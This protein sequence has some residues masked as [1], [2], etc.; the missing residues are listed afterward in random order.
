MSG[1]IEVPM[2]RRRAGWGARVVLD[3]APEPA[4]GPRV[5]AVASTLALA[6]ALQAMIDRGDVRDQAELAERLG[7]TR[8]RITQILDLTLLAPDIQTE[9]LFAIENSGRDRVTERDLRRIVR[10]VAWSEQ[11]RAWCNSGWRQ[12]RVRTPT[13]RAQLGDST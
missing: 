13:G 2:V 9:I 11:R 5:P 10:S 7:F 6:H 8:A 3:G 4:A 1:V 12:R